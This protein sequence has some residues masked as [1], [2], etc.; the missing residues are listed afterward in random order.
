MNISVV[1]VVYENFVRWR[2]QLQFNVCGVADRP[3]QDNMYLQSS[4]IQCQAS[5]AKKQG[6][7]VSVLLVVVLKI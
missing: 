4:V 3:K 2:E 6:I 1:P 7:L 5:A